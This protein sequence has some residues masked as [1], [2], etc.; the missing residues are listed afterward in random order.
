MNHNRNQH[1]KVSVKVQSVTLTICGN[2]FLFNWT[3]GPISTKGVVS[4]IRNLA[5]FLELVKAWDL[6]E[7]PLLPL[8]LASM[9]SKYSFR[10]SPLSTDKCS[11]RLSS[12]NLL[13]AANGDHQSEPQL[14]TMKRI[15]RSP[16]PRETFTLQLLH[17]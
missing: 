9:I 3:Q 2:Q 15:T 17:L 8:C 12:K 16:A 7:N 11:Y 5:S 1:G 10:S 13:F 6:D 4:G 14:N